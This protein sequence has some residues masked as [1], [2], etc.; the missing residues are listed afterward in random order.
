MF[1]SLLTLTFFAMPDA[2]PSVYPSEII[3]II[4]ID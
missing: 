4:M 1:I 3:D 2:Y